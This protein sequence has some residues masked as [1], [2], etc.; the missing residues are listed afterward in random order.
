MVRK[1][2]SLLS[3]IKAWEFMKQP[4]NV[5]HESLPLDDL[6]SSAEYKEFDKRT[7]DCPMPMVSRK[8][9]RALGRGAGIR[10]CCVA[11][12]LESYMELSPGTL[13][14]WMEFEPDWIWD[15]EKMISDGQGGM[16]QTG[17]PTPWLK[18][19]MVEKGIEFNGS[20]N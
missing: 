16:V 10:F 20:H 5:P 18:S 4:L 2:N 7:C 6:P 3:R 19:R 8:F 1:M 15:S 12:S 9:H 14:F 17:E 13:Y 11:R